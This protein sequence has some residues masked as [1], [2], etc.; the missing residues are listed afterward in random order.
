[1]KGDLPIDEHGII[2]VPDKVGV[3]AELDWD[4]IQSSCKSYKVITL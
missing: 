1:M 4:L 3:G 2:H